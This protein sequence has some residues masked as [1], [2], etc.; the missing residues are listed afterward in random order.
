MKPEPFP[1]QRV[2]EAA[3]TTSPPDGSSRPP[4]SLFFGSFP[5]SFWFPVAGVSQ[6]DVRGRSRFSAGF[7]RVGWSRG[8]RRGRFGWVPRPRRHLDQSTT[9]LQTWHQILE[10]NLLPCI[11]IIPFGQHISSINSSNVYN[12][13]FGACFNQVSSS[14][15]S[16]T[17]SSRGQPDRP[18]RTSAGSVLFRWPQELP[19]ARDASAPQQGAPPCSSV[20]VLRA[21]LGLPKQIL[22]TGLWAPEARCGLASLAGAQQVQVLPGAAGVPE[23]SRQVAAVYS[24]NCVFCC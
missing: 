21:A 20:D 10:S 14:S 11:N 5:V 18:R 24:S 22:H 15:S 9:L 23:R 13:Y 7:F 4:P 2:P 1:W 17:G 3:A 8:P 12:M 19:G 6:R 16:R